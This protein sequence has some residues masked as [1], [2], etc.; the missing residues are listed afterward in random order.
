[1]VHRV[2]TTALNNDY[3]TEYI[4]IY[5]VRGVLQGVL[6]GR[7]RNE[8]ATL[9]INHTYCWRAVVQLRAFQQVDDAASRQQSKMVQ[10]V[11]T[12]A[13]YT[14]QWRKNIW[15]NTLH[16]QPRTPTADT[17]CCNL[18]TKRWW[19]KVQGLQDIVIYT[20]HTLPAENTVTADTECCTVFQKVDDA[21]SEQ[22]DAI[23]HLSLESSKE[24]IYH[25]HCRYGVM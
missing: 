11:K 19:Y 2:K 5:S 13:L 14:V 9:Y 10:R 23:F 15:L 4:T 1:M 20:V 12:H 21:T 24:F 8:W 6:N 16:W 7:W 17:E 22:H 3:T 25:R 18:I